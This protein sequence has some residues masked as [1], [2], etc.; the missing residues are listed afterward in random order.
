MNL[1]RRTRRD[2]DLRMIDV[3]T[4]FEDEFETLSDTRKALAAEGIRHLNAPSLTVQVGASAWTVTSASTLSATK[5]I[6]ADSAI[7]E[8]NP[9]QFSNW[10]QQQ[11]TFNALMTGRSIRLRK[12]SR[13]DLAAWDAAWLALL[14]GWPVF[15]QDVRLL[16]RSGDPLNLNRVFAPEDSYEDIAHFFREAGYLHLRGW[17]AS[18]DMVKIGQ[19]ID[20]AAPSYREGDDKS[21][22][23]TVDGGERRCVRLQHFVEHSPTTARVLAS[24]AWDAVR[25]SVTGEDELTQGPIEGNC[26][27]ALLKPLG[28]IEGVSDVPW[29]RDCNFGRHAYQC[30]G[31]VVGISVDAGNEDS[32]LLRVVAGSHRICMPPYRAERDPYLPVV[33]VVTERGDVTIHQS[34]T[35]HEATPPKVRP[36]RVMYT[37]FG[38]P[39]LVD[40]SLDHA[41]KRDLEVLRERAHK[42]QSQPRSPVARAG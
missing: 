14:E 35:L 41:R 3:D 10:V 13:R 15:S 1:D 32:G 6:L 12:G 22:W 20:A 25:R 18:D 8:L 28:V 4:Y 33:P 30:A 11:A 42:L 9:E 16:D 27:E 23:A 36:R 7:V 5:G 37:G 39:P 38:L 26:I 34:C 29:H 17:L 21:W 40:N 31:A 19:E 2:A 24:D